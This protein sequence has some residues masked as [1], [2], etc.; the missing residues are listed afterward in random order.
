MVSS[1]DAALATQRA[2]LAFND[3]TF[4]A[5]VTSDPGAAENV[6]DVD[7]EADTACIGCV[8]MLVPGVAVLT[9]GA[10]RPLM[11]PKTNGFAAA[12][13]CGSAAPNLKIAAGA[14]AGAAEA[15]CPGSWNMGADATNLIPPKADL[16]LESSAAT[17][18][19]S[20][21]ACTSL[22]FALTI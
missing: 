21:V 16:V 6:I 9:C 18:A 8:A 3:R 15:V 5:T 19:D 1:T 17:A 14:G 13:C 22:R 10:A 4:S 7:A 20:S 11:P 2:K 12:F